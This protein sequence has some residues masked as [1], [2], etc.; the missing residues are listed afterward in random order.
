MAQE[1]RLVFGDVARLYERV[2]PSYPQALV[3]DV[4]ELSGIDGGGRA[5]EVGAGT[6]K[7]TRLFAARGV[8]I[9]AIDPSSQMAE[10]ARRKCAG[11][12]GVTVE[13]GEFERFEAGGERFRLLF[14]AQ[15]WHWISPE[16]RY[17]RAR[18]ALE[19]GGLLAVFWNR[20][21]WGATPLRG[22]L[23][24]AYRRAG[25][26]NADGEP[27]PMH[28]VNDPKPDPRPWER[29]IAAVA[30]FSRPQMRCYDWSSTYSADEYLDLL[31]TH[32]GHIIRPELERRAIVDEV[33]KAIEAAGGSIRF[34]MVA[35]LCLATA[36]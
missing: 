34:E 17:V 9:L 32:S 36:T 24:E 11:Y 33:G 30:G 16:V 35:V 2:R 3:D 18:E 26:L 15:A 20:P 13:E 4:V 5:L 22:E 1:Q 6:G 27:D 8:Q 21:R 31:R 29:E 14:S 23:V 28:P 10:V 25:A 7:A 12:D 19:A